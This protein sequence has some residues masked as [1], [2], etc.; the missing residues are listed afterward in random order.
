MSTLCP[1]MFGASRRIQATA[2]LL[3]VGLQQRLLSSIEAFARSLKV[4]RNTVRKQWEKQQ[5]AQ[6]E[7]EAIGHKSDW[8]V[9]PAG[10]DDERA[11][12]T[13][14]E[15]EK[16]EQAEIELA[17][18]TAESESPRDDTA[19]R[20]WRH[21][22]ELLDQMQEVAE[23]SR[24]E[25][26]VK[27]RYLIDWIRRELCPEL[28]PF[29]KDPDGSPPKWRDRRVLIFTENREGTKRYLKS[30]L[31]QMGFDADRVWLRWISAS[32]GQ[33]F[34]DTVKEMVASLKEKGPNP[35]RE[36]WGT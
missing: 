19:E 27:T 35:L 34:A 25:P 20:L 4:H 24:Y 8:L 33:Y 10:A 36:L 3:V 29:G 2:G 17:T 7:N 26:D 18:L 13:D 11:G 32:E 1:C 16:E 23:K 21:E 12:W 28:P 15:S 5:E 22:Q 9:N 31:E 6:T 30:I 14:E